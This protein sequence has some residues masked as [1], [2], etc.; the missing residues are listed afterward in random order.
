MVARRLPLL[1]TS[2]TQTYSRLQFHFGMFAD[3]P[4]TFAHPA[5]VLPLMRFAKNDAQKLALLVGAIAPDL[6][7]FIQLPWA[8][9]TPAGL[10]AIALPFA[11]MV[12]LIIYLLKPLLRAGLPS[13]IVQV[14]P[15]DLARKDFQAFKSSVLIVLG[16]STHI[17]WDSFTHRMNAI[18]VPVPSAIIAGLPAYFWLQHIS[19]ILGLSLLF[20]YYLKHTC[21]HRGHTLDALRWRILGCCFVTSLMIALLVASIAARQYAP[22]LQL[23]YWRVFFFTG[24]ITGCNGLVISFLLATLISRQ[25]L[26]LSL[27]PNSSFKNRQ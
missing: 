18:G 20:A 16:A 15:L 9:H 1:C 13:A 19:T 8:A 22:Q 25:R 14:L 23:G 26:G 2:L 6:P 4:F 17:L 24:A 5:A 27:N 7:Y 11:W 10:F 3:M 21:H 12:L